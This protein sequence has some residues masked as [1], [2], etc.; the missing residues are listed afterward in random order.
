MPGDDR[1]KGPDLLTKILYLFSGLGWL[2]IIIVLILLE[3]AK[4]QFE[5]FFDRFYHLHLQTTWDYHLAR[6]I[7]HIMIAGL[8]I[9]GIGLVVG[10]NR[11][12]RKDDVQ[13]IFLIFCAVISVIG[14]ILFKIYF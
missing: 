8:V 6:H 1:R 4:P 14:I 12:R 2:F 13:D 9:S 7:Y 11:Y 10:F 5:T 3:K